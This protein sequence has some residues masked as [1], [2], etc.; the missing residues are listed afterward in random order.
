MVRFRSPASFPCC[1]ESSI[2]FAKSEN[3]ARTTPTAWQGSACPNM[4][5]QK[6]GYRKIG[7]PLFWCEKRDLNPYGVN[8]TPLKRA[9]LPV[10]PLSH[11]T[12]V[13]A[14]DDIIL[15]FFKNV[16]TFSEISLKLFTQI[17]KKCGHRTFVKRKYRLIP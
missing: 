1:S 12:A 16:N 15:L 2:C 8:H 17:H 7:I 5:T 4:R 3:V 13:A 11:A 6:E 10:P 14:T 9:R